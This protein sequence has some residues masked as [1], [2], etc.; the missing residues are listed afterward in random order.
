MSPTVVSNTELDTEFPTETTLPLTSKYTVAF[1]N[2]ST[3]V[4]FSLYSPILNSSSTD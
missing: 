2:V 1:V 3:P 4:A